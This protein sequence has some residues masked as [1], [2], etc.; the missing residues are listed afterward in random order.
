MNS[1]SYKF[2]ILFF[3]IVIFLGTILLSLPMMYKNKIS[4]I[5]ILFTATSAV[6]V[7]G[8]SV[9]NISEK[10]SFLGQFVILMLIQ[11][12]GLG[13]MVLGSLAM[14]LFGK[15]TIAQKNIISESLNITEFR[16]ISQITKLMKK[17]VILTVIFELIG[18]VIL[19]IKFYLLDKF[20]FFK[21]IWFALFHSVSA[22][23]NAGFSLFSNSFENYKGDFIINTIIPFLIISGGLGFFVWVDILDK[24]R[25]KKRESLFL[26][27][28]IVLISTFTLLLSGFILIFLLN[29]YIYT[30]NNFLL[31]EKIF[32]SFF[33]SV[34]TRTAGFNTFSV[35]Q[36]S[37][38]TIIIFIIFM[39]IGASPGGTGGGIKTTTFFVIVKSIYDYIRGEKYVSCFKRT[40][41]ISNVLKSFVIFCVCLFWVIF[42]S[43]LMYLTSDFSY[44]EVIFETVSAFGTV[45]LSLGIT[46]QLDNYSKI[47]LIITMLFGRVG[48]LAF[49]SILFT[50]EPKEIR[51]LEEPISV[52]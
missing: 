34:T 12:G 26:H 5:D 4:F 14:V 31:K 36:F 22:F 35:S 23:C 17:V 49:F 8:L 3:A 7:T 51:Y 44:K 38:L 9:V 50:K 47:L 29:N 39:F 45:G 18:C 37:T 30:I 21:G 20:S 28:K 25:K 6:C 48:S 15:L 42:I 33:H 10:F 2:I 16:T 24:L 52:G 13:Y 40:I 19:F 1:Y 43:F 32:V 46:P 11:I 41:E 27:T